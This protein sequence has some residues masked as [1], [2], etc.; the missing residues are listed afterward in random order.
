MSGPRSQT[1]WLLWLHMPSGF[2]FC[3]HQI[4]Q[5]FIFTLPSLTLHLFSGLWSQALYLHTDLPCQIA[6]HAHCFQIASHFLSGLILG[7]DSTIHWII[8]ILAHFSVSCLKTKVKHKSMLKQSLGSGCSLFLRKF[9]FQS[10]N[11]SPKEKKSC[12]ESK[13][14]IL[15]FH[16]C[17]F[18]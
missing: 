13:V 4:T 7:S 5:L 16:P 6:A 9:N 12:S 18:L 8:I 15:N 1:L 11:L 17:Y 10:W 2:Q 14:W 3:W